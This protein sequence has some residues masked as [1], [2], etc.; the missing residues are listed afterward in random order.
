MKAYRVWN[1]NDEWQELVF[2]QHHSTDK[3]EVA[4]CYAC[5]ASSRASDAAEKTATAV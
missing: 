5:P 2:A 3:W 4:A 1:I